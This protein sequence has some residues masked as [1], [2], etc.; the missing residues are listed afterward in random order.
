MYDDYNTMTTYQTTTTSTAADP[1]AAAA[2]GGVFIFMTLLIIVV[3]VVSIISMWKLYTKAGK[4]GWS[5]IIPIYNS[6]VQLQIAGRPVW[7]ILLILL[8]PLFGAWVSIVAMIDFVRSYQRSGW[9]VLFISVLPLIALPMLAFSNKT[10]YVGP[11]AAGREE[12]DFMPAPVVPVA[13]KRT[14]KAA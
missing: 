3:S 14:K 6:I 4:P 13:A 9:W 12:V 8:V 7:W 11:I 10:Q 2:M 1:V 5:S